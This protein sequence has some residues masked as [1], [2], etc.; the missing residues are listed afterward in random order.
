MQF[1]KEGI[2][3]LLSRIGILQTFDKTQAKVSPFSLKPKQ[4]QTELPINTR[5][6]KDTGLYGQDT[7]VRVGDTVRFDT[8]IIKGADMLKKAIKVNGVEGLTALEIEEG[9]KRKVSPANLLCVKPLHKQGWGAVKI[10]KD[11]GTGL[12]ASTIQKAIA[13]LRAAETKNI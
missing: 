3:S 5:P 6:I 11:G 2:S 10:E 7:T 9:E 12:S 8:T 4:Q 1:F 13:S